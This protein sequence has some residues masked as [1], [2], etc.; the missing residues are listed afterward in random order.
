MKRGR[1]EI[2]EFDCVSEQHVTKRNVVSV[3]SPMKKAKN[4][5]YFDWELTDGKKSIRLFG[6][7][8]S[9][10]RKLEESYKSKE[11]AGGSVTLCNCEVKHAQRGEQLE[12]ST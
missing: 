3:I 2:E 10:R 11:G 7:D 1:S 12:A 9:V 5:A 6:F 4:C 8:S